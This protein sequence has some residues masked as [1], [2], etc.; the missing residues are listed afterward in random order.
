[1]L[2]RHP[3]KA[4]YHV[5]ETLSPE[6]IFDVG[7]NIGVVSLWLSEKF[8]GA[9]IYAFEPIKE[10]FELLRRNT[11]DKKN[12]R[13][14]SFGLSSDDRLTD[15][16][17]NA[18]ANNLGGFSEYQR[19][20]DADNLGN[21]SIAHKGIE[22]RSV[23][24]VLQELGLKRIDIIKVDTEGA[25]Y[26]I[27]QSIPDGLLSEVSWIMG[28]LHGRHTFETLARLDRWH[29]ISARKSLGSEVFTFQALNRA[30][31]HGRK[32]HLAG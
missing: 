7:A 1:M 20:N 2:I 4:E 6:V 17:S 12:I 11:A 13:I 32:H 25:E 5:P 15:F 27:I 26:E 23:S 31:L 21:Y 19:P 22:I 9:S 28:E 30:L 16:Y 8:P 24:A 10:N 18:D 14:F 29:T 3:R